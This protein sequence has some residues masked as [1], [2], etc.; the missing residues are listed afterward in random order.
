MDIRP[1][2]R[3]LDRVFIGHHLLFCGLLELHVLWLRSAAVLTSLHAAW[4]A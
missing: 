2:L 1:S 3:G 4:I